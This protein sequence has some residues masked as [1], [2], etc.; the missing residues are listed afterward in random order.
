MHI[1]PAGMSLHAAGHHSTPATDRAVAERG[2]TEN[3]K[4]LPR[5]VLD[6]DDSYSPSEGSRFGESLDIV[7]AHLRGRDQ[8]PGRTGSD[9]D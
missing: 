6:V 8:Y 2:A 3:R 5:S 4:K 1:H 7:N 9:R